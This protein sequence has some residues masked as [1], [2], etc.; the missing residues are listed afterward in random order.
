MA[1]FYFFIGPSGSGKS[2]IGSNLSKKLKYKFFEGDD[3]HSLKNINKMKKGIKLNFHDRRPWL[4]KINKKLKK[5]LSSNLKFI[6]ACSALKKKYRNILKQDLENVFFIYLKCRKK[7]LIKRNIS[8]NHFFPINL[9]ND[10]INT[11]ENSNDLLK[12]NSN[13]SISSVEKEVLKNLNKIT[14]SIKLT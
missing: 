13:N 1:I 5:Y 12:I 9:V 8:R 3:F 2:T 7:D 4:L 6:I 11:F 14:K 10:Q